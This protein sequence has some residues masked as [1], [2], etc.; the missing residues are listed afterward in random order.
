MDKECVSI[1]KRVITHCLV[2][3]AVIG[4][5]GTAGCTRPAPALSSSP[6]PSLSNPAAMKCL[7]DGF[8][9]EPIVTDGVARGYLCVDPKSGKKCEIWDY[10][11]GR[12]DLSEDPP[13]HAPTHRPPVK[14]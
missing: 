6:A 14:K 5:S 13:D 1:K 12:C 9:L 10:Y 3:T 4:L 2:I 8:N 11:R 7:R